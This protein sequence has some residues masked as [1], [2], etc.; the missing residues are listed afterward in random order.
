MYQKV[1]FIYKL[2]PTSLPINR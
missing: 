2:W 1:L